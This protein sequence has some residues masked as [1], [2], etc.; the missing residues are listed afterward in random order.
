MLESNEKSVATNREISEMF[1]NCKYHPKRLEEKQLRYREKIDELEK[2]KFDDIPV[3]LEA[4][5]NLFM[6]RRVK[7]NPF[8]LNQCDSSQSHREDAKNIYKM[9]ND[10]NKVDNFK[11]IHTKDTNK[12]FSPMKNNQIICKKAFD[13]GGYDNSFKI[14]YSNS[15]F[16]HKEYSPIK[17]EFNLVKDDISKY[18]E[19][20]LTN[21]KMS[22]VNNN[23][24]SGGKKGTVGKR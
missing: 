21:L 15:P 22:R 20:V 8:N 17:K 3:N 14:N 18:A 5:K 12:I 9:W 13:Y 10:L 19:A 2:S 1:K 11:K 6:M 24:G 4:V 16:Q 7:N 23:S